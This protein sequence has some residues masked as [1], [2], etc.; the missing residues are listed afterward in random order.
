M[1]IRDWSLGGGGRGITTAKRAIVAA[2]A[3]AGA[4]TILDYR[5]LFGRRLDCRVEG[6]D[7]NVR[8]RRRRRRGFSSVRVSRS[9]RDARRPSVVRCALTVVVVVPLGALPATRARR[10]PFHRR[11]LASTLR[12]RAFHRHADQYDRLARRRAVLRG[13]GAQ[14]RPGAGLRHGRGHAQIPGGEAHATAVAAERRVSLT[15][16]RA[17][18]NRSRKLLPSRPPRTNRFPCLRG[19]CS[20]IS[21]PGFFERVIF[22]L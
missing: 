10:R 11:P 12:A 20:T 6:V 7:V 15:Q 8:R 18:S 2:A 9:V 19:V 3:A 17:P 16:W 4:T 5:L 21:R 13:Q 14:G 22:V 1:Y